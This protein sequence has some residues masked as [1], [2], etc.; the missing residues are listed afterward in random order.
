[1]LIGDLD[2]APPTL[3]AEAR[4][5]GVRVAQ[6]PADKDATDL[7]LALTEA[8]ELGATEITVLAAFGG[9]LDHEVATLGLLASNTWREV[10]VAATDGRRSLWVLRSSIKLALPV[11]GS[12]SLIPWFGDVT[13]VSTEGLAWPLRSE[14]LP[15]GSTRGVSNVVASE[16]Q[17][18]AISSGVL[19]VISDSGAT[20]TS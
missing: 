16:T 20:A 15:L 7:E 10:G 8:V 11:G 14:P 2:S 17:S 6:F 13:G 18:V 19:L 9:R 12:V 1:V 4:E 5:H 3:V